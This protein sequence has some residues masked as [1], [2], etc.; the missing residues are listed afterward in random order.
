MTMY[1]E[2]LAINPDIAALHSNMGALY[3]DLGEIKPA[4]TCYGATLVCAPDH[5]EARLNLA[6]ALRS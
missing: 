1:Q 6:A 2:A 4:I 5:I 3:H